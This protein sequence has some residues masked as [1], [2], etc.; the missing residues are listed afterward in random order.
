LYGG[1]P[2]PLLAT[3]RDTDFYAEWIDSYYARDIAELFNVRDRT[4]FLLS[5]FLCDE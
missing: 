2:E 3:R 4:G 5:F 1:I